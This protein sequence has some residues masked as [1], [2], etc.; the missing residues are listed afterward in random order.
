MH[1]LEAEVIQRRLLSESDL[2]LKQAFELAQGMEAAERNT[3]SLQQT[4]TPSLVGKLDA[5]TDIT[6]LPLQYDEP[7]CP[8]LQIC[9]G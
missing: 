8:R 4:E 9:R 7:Q 5:A 3:Q 6:L 1:G 2:T